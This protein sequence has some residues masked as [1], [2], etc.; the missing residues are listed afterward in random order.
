VPLTS[1]TRFFF[2]DHDISSFIWG[3]DDFH[4]PSQ[5]NS[6]LSN[7]FR[8]QTPLL[9]SI[10]SEFEKTLKEIKDD[11][12]PFLEGKALSERLSKLA[13]PSEVLKTPSGIEMPLLLET[14]QILDLFN[15]RE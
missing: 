14:G 4:I 7:N 5:T 1:Y 3:V 9:V 15:V 10:G 6:K 8:I 12:Q 13:K 2:V 11:L